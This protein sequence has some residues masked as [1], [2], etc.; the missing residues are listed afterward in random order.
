MSENRLLPDQP[1]LVTGA[2]GYIG[3]RL[4]PRLLEAGYR[5][6]V[7]VRDPGRLDGRPWQDDVEIC[8]GDVLKPETLPAALEGV[9]AAY[10]LIHSMAGNDDF[11]DRDVVAAR[12]FGQAAAASGARSS[13][14][15]PGRK[16]QFRGP[17]AELAAAAADTPAP[18]PALR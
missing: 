18:R 8:T 1:I 16:P 3:A 2:T 4:V 14:T 11:H 13:V 6:R 12:N 5:V 17:R 9:T 10:Y 7:L 15:R